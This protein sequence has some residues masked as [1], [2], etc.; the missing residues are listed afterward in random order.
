MT[1]IQ[2]YKSD[3]DGKLFENKAK[4]I[5]HLRKLAGVRLQKKHE[6]KLFAMREEFFDKMG[7]VSSMDELNQ[8]IKDNWKW[9]W[10]NG[11]RRQSWR[12]TTTEHEFHEYVE[13][14]ICRIA[15]IETV[16][17]SHSCP[18]KG[19]Q[20]FDTNAEYNKGKPTSYPGWYGSIIIRVRPPKYKYKG[21][22]HL[23]VGWGSDYFRDTPINTGTGGGG[24]DKEGFVEYSYDLRLYAADFPVMHENIRKKEYVENENR[25]IQ[26]MWNILGGQI[27]T[28]MV[29]EVPEDWVCPDPMGIQNSI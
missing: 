25:R 27:S 11:A 29:T 9:F 10:A 13:V 6:A 7:Q 12:Y 17:N 14:K 22:E 19:V 3:T 21:V 5:K 1:I 23:H 18:R 15:W 20:N 28:P 8:F 16:R 4:Y 26:K 2:A 24:G